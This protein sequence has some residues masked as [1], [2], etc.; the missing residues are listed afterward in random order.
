M[1]EYFEGNIGIKSIEVGSFG[2]NV[3]L[4]TDSA[5]KKSI[6]IDGSSDAE[7][8][9]SELGDNQL[10]V[11]VQTHCHMDHIMALKTL[12]NKTKAR[13]GINPQE[14]SAREHNPEI[15]LEDGMEIEAGQIRLKVLH[16]PGHT[17]GS[18]SF[19]LGRFLFCGDT[20]FPGGPGKTGSPDDF[21]KILESIT[22]KIYT[23]P[24]ET[25][26][27]TGHGA[28]TTVGESKEEYK[29]FAEKK[30]D[31]AVYGDVLWLSA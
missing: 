10:E 26:L 31:H 11:I 5:A 29:V 23:L 17:P 9:L 15:A 19:L 13:L 30:R 18:V 3:Y 8:I 16:T 27:L 21:E 1:D 22:K 20:V 7:K 12:R 2:N 4:L 6:L 25:L 24:D 28:T 14:P